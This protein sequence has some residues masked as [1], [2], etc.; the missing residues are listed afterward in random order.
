[1][2]KRSACGDGPAVSQASGCIKTEKH[3]GCPG[4][5]STADKGL[6]IEQRF[7][8]PVKLVPI[9]QGPLAI[10]EKDDALLSNAQS[11]PV[12]NTGLGG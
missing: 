11:G 7:G 9:Y 1:M 4:I 10:R 2:R 6:S 5:C 3:R 8:F 12:Q